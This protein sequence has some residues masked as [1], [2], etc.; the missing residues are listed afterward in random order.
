[1]QA[2]DPTMPV[3]H[4]PYAWNA[5]S[6]DPDPPCVGKDVTIVFP[7]ANPGPDVVVV[8][9][10]DT[11]I[12]LFGIGLEWEK[13]KPVGPIILE[14]DH[15][16][17]TRVEMPW[18]P[19]SSGHRC[20]RSA[21]HV[22]G[23]REPYRIGRNLRVL[24]A[25]SDEDTWHIPFLLGNPLGR[26]AA[27]VLHIGGNDAAALA[28]SVRMGERD[29]KPGEAIWLRAHEVA[30]TEFVLSSQTVSSLH[31]VRFVEAYADG[32]LIDGLQVTVRRP[33][34]LAYRPGP[35]QGTRASQR[36]ITNV[37]VAVPVQR[38]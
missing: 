29:L 7:L 30:E 9:R 21:I 15:Q 28:A 19:P 4:R 24:E 37:L 20:V 2:I 25:A 33:T 10:I 23:A 26:P 27:F 5:I 32:V 6:I 13:L 31:H 1:M 17:I 22:A 36:S 35:I 8:E 38:P 18:T 16:H 34:G 3:R 12:A 11:E 14:P